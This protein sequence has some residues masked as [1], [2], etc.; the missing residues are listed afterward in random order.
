MLKSKSIEW[1]DEMIRTVL[2]DDEKLA[3]VQMEKLLKEYADIHI[4][5]TYT[6]PLHAVQSIQ[7]QQVD[8]IFLD[9]NMPE[10]NGLQVAEAMQSASP[11]SDII[12]ITAHDEYAIEA[13]EL[14]A[15][16][17]ILKP[18]HRN[19]LAK[20]IDRILAKRAN[21]QALAPSNQSVTIR[22]FPS[23]E[24]ERDGQVV[25]QYHWRTTKAQEL[26]AYLLH[27]RNNHVSKEALIDVLWPDFE[28]QKAMTHLYTTVYQVRQFL[29][30]ANI[31]I[32]IKSSSVN[33]G[34]FLA[35]KNVII[36]TD[37]WEQK[38]TN[39]HSPNSENYVEHQKLVDQYMGDYC[40]TYSYI[41]AE[42][43]RQRLHTIWHFHAL[44][45]AHYY[46]QQN[47]LSHALPVFQKI[48]KFQPYFEDGHFELMKIY[49]KLKEY[50]LVEQKYQMLHEIYEQ[51]LGIDIPDYIQYWYTAW[52]QNNKR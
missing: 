11:Q 7:D 2:I 46:L 23:L 8:V 42:G 1:V 28:P 45:L 31:D 29:K 52:Q 39:L 44:K 43:E 19:R 9:I 21:T 4:V 6:D 51:E 27:N 15:L 22:C 49:A 40:G 41:W 33:E 16:D 18:V 5:A 37:E 38:I 50:S 32:Q 26:F 25:R 14:N 24:F 10:L 36:E 17:Y 48:V 35:L 13:F 34:Y 47:M 20:T 3:L 12:F 30:Q